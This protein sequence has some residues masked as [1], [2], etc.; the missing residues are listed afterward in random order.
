MLN[1]NKLIKF[2][3]ILLYLIPVLPFVLWTGFTF[4]YVTIRTVLFR[5]I[6]E[7]VVCVSI[8]LW[9]EGKIVFTGFKRDYF[10]W[11]FAGLIIVESI[12]A[13]FGESPI[14]SFFGDLERMWGIFTVV[15]IFLFY[16]L[17]RVFFEEKHWKIFFHISFII[18]M[19]VSLYGILQRYPGAFGLYLFGSGEGIR[20]VSSLGNPVYVAI[21]LLFNITFAIFLLIRSKEVKAKIRYFYITTIVVDFYAFTLTDIRGAYLGLILGG[22]FSAILYIFLGT[23]KIA[24]QVICACFLFGI[25][26]LFLGFKFQSTDLVRQIPV[27]RR[28]VT[29]SIKDETARTRFIGWNAAWKGF[30]SDP[31]TGVGMENYNILFNKYF[32]AY[33]YLYAPTETYF[34]R[35]HNQF[36]NIL[37]ESGIFAFILYLGLPIVIGCYFVKG[38]RSRRLSLLEFLLFVSMSIAYFVHLFFVFDDLHSLMLFMA[39][40]GLVEYIYCNSSAF[41]VLKQQTPYSKRSLFFIFIAIIPLTIYLIFNFNYKVV[42]AAK[43]AGSAFLSEDIP[44]SLDEY[45]KAISVNLISSE[46]ITLNFVEYLMGLSSSKNIEKINSD[47]VLKDNVILAFSEAKNALELEIKKKPKDAIF[48]LKLG[49]LNNS[50]F[51]I[52]GD[53]SHLRDAIIQLEKTIVLSRERVQAYLLLGE[54]YVLAGES[55]KAIEVLQQAV[56]LEPRFRASYYYLGRALLADGKL[57]EAYDAIVNKGFIERGYEPKENMVAYVLAEELGYAG[58]YKKMVTVYEYLA[59]F[60]PMNA[61]LQSALAI[62]YVLDDEFEEAVLAAQ[63]ASELDPGFAK[64]AEIFIR[65]IQEGRIEELKKSAF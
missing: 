4:P 65:A 44:F 41:L 21:Y 14:A 8:W 31:F 60:D 58:E 23:K 5:I 20:I 2:S 37:A 63:K 1:A 53:K 35:A 36:F 29:I 15:H 57:D 59:K 12:A 13:F 33:Y 52:D 47:I 64:E 6:V 56:D 24:K 51:L 45:R 32:P 17:T 11:S 54:T 42:L 46:N 55:Q 48:Y 25:I 28:V 27:L 49:Q 16:V 39:F 9:I 40:V 7:I 19:L 61:R 50:Q 38:Y 43:Y 18:S 34:D 3:R 26:I 62:A 22:A 10:F 30:L